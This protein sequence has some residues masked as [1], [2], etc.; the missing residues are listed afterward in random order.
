MRKSFKKL[1]R[2]SICPKC[3]KIK[4]LTAHHIFPKRFFGDN[5][6]KLYICRDCHDE[7]EEIIPRYRKLAK[8]DYIFLT[9]QWLTENF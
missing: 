6:S 1:E 9:K 8:R 5:N 3:F 4:K 2:Y 7:I